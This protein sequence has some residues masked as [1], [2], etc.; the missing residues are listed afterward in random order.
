[1]NCKNCRH[2]FVNPN[3]VIPG[4][5]TEGK[6][7]VS[8]IK[9]QSNHV[10][11]AWELS[12]IAEWKDDNEKLTAR[13]AELEESDKHWAGNVKVCMQL[14]ER[15]ESDIAELEAALTNAR[16]LIGMTPPPAFPGW[17]PVKEKLPNL[18]KTVI[19]ARTIV[20]GR[21]GGFDLAFNSG[22]VWVGTQQD[23]EYE[24][25]THWMPLPEPPIVYGKEREE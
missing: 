10:C 1:M 24:D 5:P 13:I 7:L 18:F 23:I 11:N 9:A 16:E 17:I 6:C 3:I 22:L 25:V 2:W 14:I 15:Y 20:G 12:Q 19:I 4:E 8:E 21:G